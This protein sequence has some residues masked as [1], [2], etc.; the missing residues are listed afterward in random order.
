MI[1]WSYLVWIFLAGSVAAF[2]AL[3]LGCVRPERFPKLS[4]R[5]TLGYL[6]LTA[7]V[8]YLLMA[9][10]L[11]LR[12]P[13]LERYDR[14]GPAATIHDIRGYFPRRPHPHTHGSGRQ[15]A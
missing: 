3:T 14:L 11:T 7:L 10:S 9:I 15:D 6:A 1:I 8:S 12:D 13:L 4:R 2:I 5:S